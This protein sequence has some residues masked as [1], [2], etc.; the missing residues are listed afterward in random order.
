[1]AV[2]SHK[3]QRVAVLIDAQNLYHSARHL[4]KHKVNFGA[5]LKEAVGERQ[6]VRAVAYVISTEAGD[7]KQFFDALVRVG[8]ETKT[9]DLQV[10]IDGSKKADWDVGIAID[11]VIL[12]EKVDVIVIVSGD[13]D[14]VPMVRY[15]KN[16]V[17]VEGMNFLQSTSSKLVEALDAFTDM[18]TE[19]KK[20]LLGGPSMKHTTHKRSAPNRNIKKK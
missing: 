9:K 14:F 12:S 17:Q 15:L 1:M 3:A 2:I 19:P 20:Y 4:Y 7:E 10:F 6:L 11:A 16:K 8:I 13:G 18:G 5:I